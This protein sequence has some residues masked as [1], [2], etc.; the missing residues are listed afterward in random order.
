MEQLEI[1]ETRLHL[2][3]GLGLNSKPSAATAGPVSSASLAP[4]AIAATDYMFAVAGVRQ[5]NRNSSLTSGTNTKAG[6]RIIRSSA[7]YP[8]RN[9]RLFFSNFYCQESNSTEEV[10]TGT[11]QIE[12]V[13]ITVT[14]N[15]TTST[16]AASL[17]SPV[18]VDPNSANGGVF[19]EVPTPWIPANTPLTISYASA[20]AAGT[21][22]PVYARARPGETSRGHDTTS[23][24]AAVNSGGSLGVAG[25]ASTN[26]YG[27]LFCP[28]YITAQGTDGRPVC[29]NLGDSIGTGKG[30]YDSVAPRAVIGLQAI[31]MDESVYSKVWM[32]GDRTLAGSSPNA[33][34]SDPNTWSRTIALLAQNGNR[35]FNMI[36]SEHGNNTSLD[37]LASLKTTMKNYVGRLRSQFP[38]VPIVQSTLVVKATSTDGFRTL[39]NQVV[40]N[41]DSSTGTRF[42]YNDDL[43]STKLDGAVD[44][45]VNTVGPIQ[46]DA[47]AAN[48]DHIKIAP[49]SATLT[50]ATTAGTQTIYLSAAPDLNMALVLDPT[51]GN[52]QSMV[53]T[54]VATITAGSEYQVGVSVGASSASYP[55][56]PVGTTVAQMYFADGGPQNSTVHMSYAADVLIAQK[57]WAPFKNSFATA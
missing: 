52:A 56:R 43:L 5:A 28:V 22:M 18:T 15:G 19:V 29:W 54:S 23:F 45:V 21:L 13:A 11:Y 46:Y 34:A 44:Y 8:T 36:L 41:T 53:V 2:G 33:L 14:V 26:W 1:E 17:P 50:R 12:A 57:A 25:S 16:Y 24:A 10:A 35:P 38:D 9:I 3:L 42:R 47:S 20:F 51:G 48:R 31:G 30:Q 40:N 27:F 49:F 55:A 37:D 6:T 39:A 7:P 4:P 32:C